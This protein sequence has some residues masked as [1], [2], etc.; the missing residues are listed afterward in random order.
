MCDSYSPGLHSHLRSQTCC[1]KYSPVQIFFL[2]MF[3]ENS[4]L[5][6]S[7]KQFMATNDDAS[8]PFEMC[9]KNPPS[10]IRFVYSF[11]SFLIRRR[12]FIINVVRA[13]RDA[14]CGRQIERSLVP[15]VK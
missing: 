13:E 4:F 6:L 7:V 3:I 1:G 14:S 9:T 5:N 10:Q 11:Y 8:H 2:G 12:K 15:L